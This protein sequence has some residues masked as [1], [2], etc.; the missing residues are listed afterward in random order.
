[1]AWLH[2][3]LGS[4]SPKLDRPVRAVTGYLMQRTR[5]FEKVMIRRDGYLLPFFS[6]SNIALTYWVS[7][8]FIDPTE[9]FVRSILRPGD[10]FID[11]GANVGTVA[12]VA[13]RLVGPHGKVVAIEPHPRTVENLQQTVSVNAFGNVVCLEVACGALSGLASLTDEKRKDDNNRFDEVGVG[14][15]VR[16]TTLAEIVRTLA[17]EKVSLLKIDVEGFEGAVLRG[18]GREFHR[19][20]AIYI[21]VI[22]ANLQQCGDSTADIISLLQRNGFAC[23][24]ISEDSTNLAALSTAAQLADLSDRLVSVPGNPTLV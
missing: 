1:M 10:V 11:V 5:L 3:L 12:S 22:E 15:P 9:Q 16:V 21:E 24:L 13:A 2:Q 23:F 6:S 19:V 17:L 14:V 18:L 4:E 7:P 8:D 20:E